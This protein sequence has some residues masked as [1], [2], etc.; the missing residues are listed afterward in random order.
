MNGVITSRAASDAG[1]DDLPVIIIGAGLVGCLL[2]CTLARRGLTVAVYERRPDPRTNPPERGRSVNLAL[3]RRGISA[4]EHLDL[5]EAVMGPSLPMTGRMIHPRDGSTRFQRYHATGTEAIHSISRSVL[6]ATLLQAAAAMPGVSLHFDHRLVDIDADAGIATLQSPTG[7]VTITGAV[8]IGADGSRS[9]VRGAL[10]AAGHVQV[11]EDPLDEGYKELSIPPRAD[12]TF[13]LDEQ[14][15]HIWPRGESM[16]IALPNPDGSFTGTLYWPRTGPN[17]FEGCRTDDEVRARFERDYPDARALMPNLV[18]DYRENPVGVLGTVHTSP[19]TY[20]RIALIGDAAHAILPFYGQGA[21][22]GFE[23]VVALDTCLTEAH[24]DWGIALG[25][26]QRARQGNAE[27]IAMM[28]SQNYVEMR[29]KVNS[30]IFHAGKRV[31]HALERAL[32]GLY[33]SR[34]DMVSFSTIPYAEVLRRE[35]LQRLSAWGMLALGAAAM[36]GL[37]AVATRRRGRT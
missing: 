28:A 5:V 23:D 30:P 33:R 2:A 6:N 26:Y 8:V 4:L 31:E 11:V 13:A 19:W 1:S 24:G 17:S 37:I 7:S 36:T 12:G 32:P 10:A 21:N 35:R 20:G 3:S 16:M 22:C 29:D 18:E 34:Y 9:A 14:A 25:E 27:A 15:L